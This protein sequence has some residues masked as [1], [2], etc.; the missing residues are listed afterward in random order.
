[1]WSNI[2]KFGGIALTE[3][4]FI[5]GVSGVG[6]STMAHTLT[7]ELKSLGYAV[8]EY[9][10][11]DYT[12]PIDFYCTAYL[13]VEEYVELCEKHKSFIEILHVNTIVAGNVRLV[14]YYNQDTPLFNEPLLSELAQKEFCYNPIELVTRNEYTSVY[15]NIWK[16]FVA[17]ID[18]TYDFIVFD[19]SL[20]HHPIN[21]MMRNYNITGKQAISHVTALLNA[22]GL[23]T[24][25]IFYL[26]TNSIGEQ[27]KKARLNR[28]QKTPTKEQINFW[29]TRYKNDM[30]VLN[31]IQKDCQ[32]YDVSDDGWKL[33]REQILTNLLN[34]C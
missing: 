13:S 6:K 7:N 10:E 14:R 11:F 28:G 3:L 21:D 34:H 33:A 26:R 29:E 17:A 30:M 27:L 32:V 1:M 22:L 16:S 19:G 12:N 15:I 25:H 2:N 31:N 5:E 18:E 23:R 4:V 20:L 24:W 8:K 9:I